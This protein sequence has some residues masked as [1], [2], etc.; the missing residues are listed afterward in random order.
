[1]PRALLLTR[2]DRPIRD[3]DMGGAC[4]LRP[5]YSDINLFSYGE[6]VIDLDAEITHGALNLSVPEQQLYRAQILSTPINERC[7]GSA[8][9]VRPEKTW[10]QPNARDPSRYKS[11]ILASGDAS[12]RV[13]A[14]AK[15][16]FPRL[17]TGG[18]KV[19]VNRRPS[20]FGQLESD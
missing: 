17:F 13:A 18:P 12:I 15:Q 20:Q 5:R 6:R 4:T 3:E 8:K 16:E 14:A 7:L 1:M 2:P 9:R 11:R 10:V 19:I